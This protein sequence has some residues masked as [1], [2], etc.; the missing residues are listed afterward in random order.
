MIKNLR[1]VKFDQSFYYQQLTRSLVALRVLELSDADELYR[2]MYAAG[3]NA[4]DALS[5]CFEAWVCKT[6]NHVAS[7]KTINGFF[8]YCILHLQINCKGGKKGDG[9]NGKDGKEGGP[10]GKGGKGDGKKGGKK[11]GKGN[12]GKKGAP[13]PAAVL[14]GAAIPAA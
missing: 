7:A 9:K 13:P 6:I 3:Q 10:Y 2:L 14:P 12:G 4:G 8:H 5:K 11:G 1:D